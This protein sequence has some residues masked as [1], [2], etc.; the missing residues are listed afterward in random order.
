[1]RACR[2]WRLRNFTSAINLAHAGALGA[3]TAAFNREDYVAAA[4]ILGPL[5]E[6]GVAKAQAYLGF[7]YVNGRGVP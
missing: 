5:V 4:A 3:G 6:R 2:H 1:M 7:M